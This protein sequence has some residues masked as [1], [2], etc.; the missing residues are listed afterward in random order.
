MGNGTFYESY[1]S[2]SISH[3][4]P[5]LLTHPQTHSLTHRLI[6]SCYQ[7]QKFKCHGPISLHH[8]RSP[9][10]IYKDLS[11]LVYLRTTAQARRYRVP[12]KRRPITKNLKLKFHYFTF[13]IITEQTRNIFQFR[14]TGVFFGKPCIYT[15]FYCADIS[16]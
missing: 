6:M 16:A 4:F 13:L 14:E 7:P 8:C 12:H 3:P 10:R 5:N 9:P 1:H 11:D 2:I 15:K